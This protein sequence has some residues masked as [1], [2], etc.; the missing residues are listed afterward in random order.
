MSGPVNLVSPAGVPVQSTEKA[1]PALR[2]LGYTD[3]KKAAKPKPK[4]T[5]SRKPK[6]QTASKG[7][8]PFS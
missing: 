4:A 8:G 7:A 1:A 2:R 6:R 3:D 5:S